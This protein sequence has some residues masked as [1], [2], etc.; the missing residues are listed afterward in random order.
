MAAS[1]PF[2]ALAT[3]VARGRRARR[4]DSAGVREVRPAG[5]QDGQSA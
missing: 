4:A 5:G 1:Q 2:D 3:E